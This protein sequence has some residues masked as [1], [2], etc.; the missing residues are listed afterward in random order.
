MLDLGCGDGR[1]TK[2]LFGGSFNKIDLWGFDISEK[3]VSIAK[4]QGI[5]K[6]VVVADAR[7]LP[8]PD[9]LFANV[10]SNSVLEHIVEEDRVLKEVSRVLKEGG[11]FIFTVPSERFV[12][13]LSINDERYVEYLN[14]R[15]EHY[16]YHSP[17]EWE[18]LLRNHGLILEQYRYFIPKLAQLAWEKLFR[19][20]TKKLQGYE[21]SDFLGLKRIGMWFVMRLFSPTVFKILLRK[22]YV[23]G[24]T[25]N[26]EG[27]ALLI[28]AR[29]VKDDKI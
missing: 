21:L 8:Y 19:F 17:R 16:H 15:L 24:T 4:S 25:D 18:R 11:R 2:I 6:S 28:V 10:L 22:W 13:N 9:H 1:F 7:Y 20:F 26:G 3:V 14:K 5:Y 27:G 23:L 12:K 29:K